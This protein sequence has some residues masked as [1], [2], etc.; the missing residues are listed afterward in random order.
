[1]ENCSISDCAASLLTSPKSDS[2]SA[3]RILRDFC[4]I[5]WSWCLL[6]N[7]TRTDNFDFSNTPEEFRTINADVNIWAIQTSRQEAPTRHVANTISRDIIVANQMREIQVKQSLK[8]LSFNQDD[9]LYAKFYLQR[10]GDGFIPPRSPISAGWVLHCSGC[11]NLL[12]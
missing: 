2:C 12:R 11:T 6:Y 3:W 8:T 7:T 10:L 9:V 1:M 5:D 4:T